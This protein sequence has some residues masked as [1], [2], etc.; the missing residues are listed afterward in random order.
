[1]YNV[2][3]CRPERT[4][5]VDWW[6]DG[7][8]RGERGGVRHTSLYLWADEV[9][10]AKKTEVREAFAALGGSSAGLRSVLVADNVGTLRT[11][12]DVIVDAELDDVKSVEALSRLRGVHRGAGSGSGSYEVR[13]D[14]T[15][16]APDP[17]R[18]RPSGCSGRH[19]RHELVGDVGG[20]D[21][22][23]LGVVVGR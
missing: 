18:M 14:G 19:Q 10:D 1:M 13:V 4:A 17:V 22:R 20:R 3:V 7:P 6:Y 23:D 15:N 21:R 12:Y 2:S 9:A 8:P 11:D 5:R 16:H